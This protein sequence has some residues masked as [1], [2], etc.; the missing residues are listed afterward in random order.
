MIRFKKTTGYDTLFLPGMDHSGIS[1]Q[2][3]VEEKLRQQ[4]IDK[5]KLGR[6]NFLKEA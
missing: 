5:Y 2:V 1:T 4:N 6:E 3:K